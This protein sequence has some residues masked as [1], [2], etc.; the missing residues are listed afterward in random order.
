MAIIQFFTLI[1]VFQ[2]AHPYSGN[3]LSISGL[4]CT[5]ISCGRMSGREGQPGRTAGKDIQ[6]DIQKDIRKDIREGQPGRT[7][8]K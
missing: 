8:G 6:K 2:N 7:S 5:G 1:W 4:G 3:R